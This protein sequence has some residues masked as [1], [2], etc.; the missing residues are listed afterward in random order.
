MKKFLKLYS[1][2]LKK[3]NG[4]RCTLLASALVHATV[5]SLFPL[6]LGTISFSLYIMGSS[7]TLLEKVIPLLRQAFPVGIDE[8]AQSIPAIKQTS[9]VLAAGGILAFFWGSAS[10]FRALESTLNVI[11]KIKRDRPFFRRSLLTIGSALLIF[12]LLILS[13]GIT[14]W[15]ETLGAGALSRFMPVVTA[16][17][18]EVNGL[19]HAHREFPDRA[20]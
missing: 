17:E 11:W 16:V 6:I 18:M 15:T 13:V 2:A 1:L 4:D 8:I 12:I 5:F 7:E 14:F 19:S 20:A 10:I 9:I 3:F